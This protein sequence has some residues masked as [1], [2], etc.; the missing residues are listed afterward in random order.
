MLQV[1]WLGIG[2]SGL[3]KLG[4]SLERQAFFLQLITEP[5]MTFTEAKE[6]IAK[7]WG[8]PSFKALMAQGRPSLEVFYKQVGKLM[9]ESHEEEVKHLRAIIENKNA[10]IETIEK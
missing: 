3:D 5:N 9:E 2:N 6:T 4:D 8:L 10:F 1:I 7:A